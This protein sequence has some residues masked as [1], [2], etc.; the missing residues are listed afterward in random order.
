[1]ESLKAKLLAMAAQLTECAH[2]LDKYS[3]CQGMHS[4][5]A[6]ESNAEDATDKTGEDEPMPVKS[7]KQ[8]KGKASKYNA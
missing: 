7:M 4:D 5:A 2:N 6:S 8:L 3:E 1:M